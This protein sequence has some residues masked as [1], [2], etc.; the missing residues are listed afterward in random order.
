MPRAAILHVDLTTGKVRHEPVPLGLRQR[1]IGGEGINSWLL[2]DHFLKVDP[3]ADPLGPDNVLIAGMGP[4]GATPYGAGSKMKWTFKSPLTGMFGDSVCGGFFGPQL[5]WAGYDH[6][7]ITGR[8]EHPVYLSIK[9]DRVEIRDARHLWGKGIREADSLIRQE[10]GEEVEVAAIGQAGENLVRFASIIASRHRA[11]GR[12]GGGCVM[13]SKNLKAIAA[14]GT[15]GVSIYDPKAFF[16]AVDQ[17]YAA[18]ERVGRNRDGWK[19]F[20]TLLITGHYQKVG[21]NAFRNDQ[22]SSL[23]EEKYQKLGH[24]WFL[25][26]LAKGPLSCSPGCS[27]GCSSYYK[28]TGNESP[29]A[30]KYAGEVGRKPEYLGV[31]SFG[32]VT[33]LADMTAVGHLS[34]LCDHYGMDITETGAL[35]GLL[36]ELWQRGII[37][38]D[39]TREWWGEPVSLDWGNYQAVERIIHSIPATSSRL[40]GLLRE[41]VRRAAQQI[42]EEKGVDA[43]RY[44]LYGKGGAAFTET[45]RHRPGWMVNMAVPSRGADHLKGQL[46]MDPASRKELAQRYFGKPE[47]G[48]EFL[49]PSYKGALSALAENHMAA[50]NSLGVCTM[51]VGADPVRYPLGMFAEA[52]HAATG[53]R[54][55]PEEMAQA[56]ERIVNLEKSF[57]TRLGFRREHDTVC[58]RWLKEEIKEGLGKGWK[59]E[60]YLEQAKDEYYQFHGW[61]RATSL[62]TRAKLAELGLEDVAAVLA[63][64]GALA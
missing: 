38:A 29:A 30:A 46:T 25:E 36:L 14:L 39:D 62:P 16:Q 9:D 17:L 12:A 64:E 52:I 43:L 34:E 23:P 58:Y 3:M 41:G 57:N 55:T 49:S 54:L 44:A 56:G 59:A 2:W 5:R 53:L 22:A 40:G 27:T 42:G 15:R 28:V 4:L 18:L 31:A 48:E 13:G 6:L 7:V 35:C 61:D 11:A 60:D 26:H 33:D 24:R 8:A 20:G 63:K 51:M 47:A 21:V 32:I 37:T 10:V 45:L 50:I 1:F 19:M